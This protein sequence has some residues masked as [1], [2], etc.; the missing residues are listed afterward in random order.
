MAIVTVTVYPV[1]FAA[2]KQVIISTN[3]ITPNVYG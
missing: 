1:V 2:E 3:V